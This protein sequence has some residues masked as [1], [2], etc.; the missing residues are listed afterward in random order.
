M[1]RK[2]LVCCVQATPSKFRMATVVLRGDYI[3]PIQFR[4]MAEI[5]GHS[6]TATSFKVSS[7]ME[8]S[9]PLMEQVEAFK[10]FSLFQVSQVP[11]HQ[12]TA[13]HVT[14]PTIIARSEQTLVILQFQMQPKISGR[15]IPHRLLAHHLFL[16]PKIREH[17]RNGSESDS[18]SIP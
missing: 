11:L 9:L 3:F 12:I 17:I 16:A 10:L 7:V 15:T 5:S 4:L 2:S 13:P 14:Q 8:C 6:L 1:S 18:F